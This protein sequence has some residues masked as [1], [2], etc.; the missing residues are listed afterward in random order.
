[1]VTSLLARLPKR[2]HL[3]KLAGLLKFGVRLRQTNRDHGTLV[4]L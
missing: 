1:M 3:P 4:G 2:K